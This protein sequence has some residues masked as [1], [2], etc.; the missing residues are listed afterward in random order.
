MK[1]IFI[2]VMMAA[3]V[4]TSSAMLVSCSKDDSDEPEAVIEDQTPIDQV[5]EN[6]GNNTGG[7]TT[8]TGGGTTNNPSDGPIVTPPPVVIADYSKVDCLNGS[9]YFIIRLNADAYAYLETQNKI[10]ERLDVDDVNTKFYVWDETFSVGKLT[11]KDC[12]GNDTEGGITSINYGG[13]CGGGWCRL[14]PFDYSQIDESYTLH[15][16]LRCNKS[17]DDWYMAFQ[18]PQIGGPEYKITKESVDING[19][20]FDL[21]TN[22]EWKEFEFSIADMIDAGVELINFDGSKG[23]NF[24]CYGGF[25]GATVDM[26]AIFIYK[27]K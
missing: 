12:F 23:I 20:K 24:P 14:T 15:I 26:D 7:G 13:W 6:G 4:L 17:C 10:K 1:R 18:N 9:D 22:G 3:A 27:K 11:G 19:N 16:S 21:N 5:A 8:N 2:N 25:V